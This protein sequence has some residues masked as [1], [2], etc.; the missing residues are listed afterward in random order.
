MHIEN[1][2]TYIHT[3]NHNQLLLTKFKNN[4]CHIEPMTPK[5]HQKCSPLQIIGLLI[6]KTWGRGCVIFGEQ[7]NKKAKWLNSF[8]NG[9]IF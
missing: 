1:I 9:E 3:I 7:K 6:E 8:K 2:Y 5:F 4:L